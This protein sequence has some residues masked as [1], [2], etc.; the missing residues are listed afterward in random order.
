MNM[1]LHACVARHAALRALAFFAVAAAA[2]VASAAQQGVAIAQTIALSPGW[3]AV[4][5][6]LDPADPAP[7]RVFA[8]LPVDAVATHDAVPA[9]GQFV[10]NPGV[11]LALAQGWAVWYAPS[12]PDAFLSN[13]YEMQGAKAYLVHA[14]TNAT[15][16]LAGEAPPALPTWKPD[17]FNFVGFPLQDPGS[18]TFAQFFAG[19]SAHNSSRI[20][21]LADGKWRQVLNPAAETMRAGEAFWIHCQG[22]SDYTGPVAVSTPSPFG[23]FLSPSGGGEIVFR[24]RAPHPVALRL[25]HT[26]DSEAPVPISVEIEAR[27]EASG[28]LRKAAIHL[29]AGNWEQALPTLEA[30]QSIRLPLALRV[31]D[32]P[33]GV[34]R[35]IITVFTDLGTKTVVPVTATRDENP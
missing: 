18:P 2:E 28:N 17:A 1:T 26:A 32:M 23:I 27:D 7:G 22:P 9:G 15:L 35:S 30:G 14:T 13:L 16:L 6:E 34:R 29:P 11:D 4:Y 20:Y 21:R 19:S 12:R 25:A 24:N 3:N 31:Q 5:L 8:G 10:K 33:A